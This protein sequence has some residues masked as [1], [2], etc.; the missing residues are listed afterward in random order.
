MT[1]VIERMYSQALPGAGKGSCAERQQLVPTMVVRAF[2]S[3]VLWTMLLLAILTRTSHTLH[4]VSKATVTT[5]NPETTTDTESADRGRNASDLTPGS[6]YSTHVPQPFSVSEAVVQI[7]DDNIRYTWDKQSTSAE[8]YLTG[9][10]L[11]VCTENASTSTS[12]DRCHDPPGYLCECVDGC[13]TYGS[14][15]HDRLPDLTVSSSAGCLESGSYAIAKCPAE[16]SQAGIR[17][18]CEAGVGQ[19][20]RD[21]PVSDVTTAT[22]FR[23]EFCATCHGASTFEGWELNVT[24][25][26][27]QYLYAADTQDAFM[28]LVMQNLGLCD[29]ERVPPAGTQPRLCPMP[30]WFSIRFID[31]CN[32]TGEWKDDDY[33]DDVAS[34]C[35]LY[36][37]LV[38]QVQNSGNVFQNLFCAIC[39]GVRPMTGVCGHGVN[40]PPAPHPR[41]SAAPLSLLLGLQGPDD[42]LETDQHRLDCPPGQ[43]LD[44][45]V[46]RCS[47]HGSRV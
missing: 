10:G 30:W 13:E 37:S 47:V 16:W 31:T 43:W 35:P 18:K 28:D 7:F 39:N 15:C 3:A 27:F 34:N 6:T 8:H 22:T 4:T 40:V 5:L 21:E 32:V 1:D 11:D 24:C 29:V 9:F 41:V 12:D 33:D 46:S 25:D 44:L 38:L 19:Y 2:P 14:C 23:N 26:H 20:T 45:K 17:E 36:K 42:Q